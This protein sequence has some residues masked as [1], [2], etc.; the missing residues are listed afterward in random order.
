MEFGEIEYVLGRV[1]WEV[2]WLF[3]CINLFFRER[4]GLG[5]YGVYIFFE[6]FLSCRIFLGGW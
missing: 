6:L 4:L 2:I 3:G 5:V 1:M